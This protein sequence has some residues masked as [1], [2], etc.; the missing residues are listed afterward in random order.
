MEDKLWTWL[1]KWQDHLR[2]Q[3][4]DI[5]IQW[6]DELKDGDQTYLGRCDY[7]TEHNLAV[8]RF[9]SE[10]G[11]IRYKEEEG[12]LAV[13]PYDPEA[14]VLHELLHLRFPCINDDKN[15]THASLMELGLNR[16]VAVL[17]RLSRISEQDAISRA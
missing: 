1:F 16:V 4:W 11:Y 5:T 17:M 8:I 15:A 7:H 13:P 2:L 6:V 14:T 10:A 9:L 12:D 3:D